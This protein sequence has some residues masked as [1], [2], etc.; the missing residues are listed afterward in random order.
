MPGRSGATARCLDRRR[1]GVPALACGIAL[2][3]APLF[4]AQAA[5]GDDEA[6]RKLFA[7][8]ASPPCGL[9]HV[10]AAAGASGKIGPSLDEMKPDA[11]RVERAVKQGV[12][13]MPPF[14]DSLTDEQIAVLARYVARASGA[15]K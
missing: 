2:L 15:S 7:E 10:L 8:V 3:L 4:Q 1:R 9:C 11:D 13:V 6:G 12:G 5:A 14:E